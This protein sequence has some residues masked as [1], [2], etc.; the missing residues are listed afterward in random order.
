MLHSRLVAVLLA[1]C[2]RSHCP[3]RVAQQQ[4]CQGQKGG[5][6]MAYVHPAKLQGPPE[7]INPVLML[8][9]FLCF[10]HLCACGRLLST[11]VLQSQ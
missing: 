3:V 7:C 9:W 1:E 4:G 2:T 11:L 6:G 5:V 10:P 8:C